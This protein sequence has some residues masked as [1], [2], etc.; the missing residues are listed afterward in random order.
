[1][2]FSNVKKSVQSRSVSCMFLFVLS[3]QT[4]SYQLH[5]SHA[6]F[7]PLIEAAS[8]ATALPFIHPS[9]I[10]SQLKKHKDPNEIITTV[11]YVRHIPVASMV[12]ILMPLI[13]RTGYLDGDSS[14]NGIVISDR[15]S[16]VARVTKLIKHMDQPDTDEMEVV[17]L[18]F[19]PAAEIVDTINSIE[20]RTYAL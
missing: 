13:S 7:T 5:T 6:S 12:P 10:Q 11:V 4:E 15:I 2:M 19:A 9:D 8:K 14:I 1:M 17:T 20:N 3:A 16:N 18:R